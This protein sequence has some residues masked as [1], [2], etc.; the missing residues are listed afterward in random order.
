MSHVGGSTVPETVRRLLL[1]II[2]NSVA[3]LCN[4]VGKNGKTPFSKLKLAEVV[5]GKFT[6]NF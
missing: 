4:W 5:S 3:K 2:D 6:S 1:A